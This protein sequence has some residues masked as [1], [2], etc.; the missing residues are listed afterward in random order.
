MKL[1]TKQ[2]EVRLVAETDLET[3][4]LENFFT[5]GSLIEVTKSS[6]MTGFGATFVTLS[7]EKE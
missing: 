7:Y 5:N 4:Y 1:E 6:N 3:Y 2:N